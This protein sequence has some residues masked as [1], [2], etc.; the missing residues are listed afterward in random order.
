MELTNNISL[1]WKRFG[2]SQAGLHPSSGFN[3]ML[4]ELLN[5]NYFFF[6]K[7]VRT[8]LV[9]QWPRSSRVRVL[10]SWLQRGEV[11]QN[12]SSE[13]GMA[14]GCRG[15]GF[16]MAA[17]HFITYHANLT[18]PIKHKKRHIFATFVS[19]QNNIVY[20]VWRCLLRLYERCLSFRAL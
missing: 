17:K 13:T 18:Q 19:V 14:A 5:A 1:C 12:P 3:V 2:N 20:Q 8:C 10:V 7:S 4:R 16:L 11:H 9:L 6:T 15:D